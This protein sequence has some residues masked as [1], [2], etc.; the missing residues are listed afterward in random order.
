[1]ATT[2]DL[3]GSTRRAHRHRKRKSQEKG[4]GPS[5][6]RPRVMATTV[7]LGGS[8]RRAHRHRKRRSQENGGT[9][10]RA[11]ATTVNLGGSTR[12]AHLHSERRTPKS[13][14]LSLPAESRRLQTR[15]V[16]P[17]QMH[18]AVPYAP[19]PFCFS[20]MFKAPANVMSRAL[21]AGSKFNSTC[22]ASPSLT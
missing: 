21:T 1:M 13:T 4:Q 11:M 9:R 16:F 7:N 17:T 3:G 12:R 14:P 10:K 6:K 2:V 15:I 8:T 22:F 18:R 20:Q 19:N 5:N